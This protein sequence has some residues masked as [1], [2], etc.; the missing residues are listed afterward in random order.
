MEQQ[1]ASYKD[2]LLKEKEKVSLLV[3]EVSSVKKEL[4]VKHQEL[5]IARKEA[6]DQLRL[7]NTC[8]RVLIIMILCNCVTY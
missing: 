7:E 6:K 3:M 2:D 8:T 4:E 5:I 1:L